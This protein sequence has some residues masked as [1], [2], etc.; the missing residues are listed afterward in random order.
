M[1]TSPKSENKL[2]L[3]MKDATAKHVYIP[4]P[5][6]SAAG[7]K[8]SKAST[9]T[10]GGAHQKWT[11]KGRPDVVYHPGTRHVGTQ[12]E[13]F[14][15]FMSQCHWTEAVARDQVQKVY[16]LENT[17]P[18]GF[19]EAAYMNELEGD[20]T[21]RDAHRKIASENVVDLDN[22][23]V[24]LES[25]KASAAG[26]GHAA[27]APVARGRGATL[28]LRDKVNALIA[29]GDF[30]TTINVSEYKAN[31][32]GARANAPALPAVT[33]KIRLSNDPSS[34]L[35]RLV[36]VFTRKGGEVV[37][38]GEGSP[39]FLALQAMGLSPAECHAAIRAV[40]PAT[41]VIPTSVAASGYYAAPVPVARAASPPRNLGVRP[42]SPVRF[43]AG[44]PA[45]TSFGL[46]AVSFSGLPAAGAPR[47]PGRAPGSSG[48]APLP[49]LFSGMTPT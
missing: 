12:E 11:S 15:F 5:S 13:L 41:A 18:G 28:S 19:M 43:G 23:A 34:P 47:S 1:S 39:V 30:I 45:A 40:N 8:K 36:Y 29:K 31:G 6:V 33:T 38:T 25:K 27:S 48:R 17:K 42:P 14:N 24:L 20:K 44:L 37:Q 46:P 9:V 49:T 7:V 22:L 32:T 35:Y 21:Y 10:L 16:T 26:A 2:S 3:K 4:V